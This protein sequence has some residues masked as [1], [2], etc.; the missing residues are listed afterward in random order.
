MNSKELKKYCVRLHRCNKNYGVVV[1]AG[2]CTIQ[3]SLS[4]IGSM[5]IL[6]SLI[7]HKCNVISQHIDPKIDPTFDPTFDPIFYPFFY[8]NLSK[9]DF[10]KI[11]SPLKGCY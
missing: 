10:E 3:I 5:Y 6:I 11:Y 4:K 2:V 9:F 8:P 7:K 1:Y